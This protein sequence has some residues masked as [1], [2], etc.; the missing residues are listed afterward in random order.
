MDIGFPNESTATPMHKL[1]FAE[2]WSTIDQ[3]IEESTKPPICCI[4]EDCRKHFGKS[5][6]PPSFYPFTILK[7]FIAY[8]L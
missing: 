3:R 7:P 8:H 2:F 4:V 5:L 1:F 6:P